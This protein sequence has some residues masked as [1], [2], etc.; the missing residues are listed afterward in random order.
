MRKANC[1]SIGID[2]STFVSKIQDGTIP[3]GL[4]TGNPDLTPELNESY[5]YG[6]V[7]TPRFI[8]GLSIAADYYNLVIEDYIENMSFARSAATC[9][10]SNDFPNAEACSTFERDENHQVVS[11]IERPANVALSTF[12]S[13]TVRAFY[14]LPIKNW[15]LLSFDAFTQ[16][17]ITN[18]FQATPSSEIQEDVGD[19]G[20]PKWNG[21]FDTKWQI[22]DFVFS[23]RLRWQGKGRIDA[24][25]QIL[26]AAH[27]EEVS[28][29][30]YSGNFVNETDAVYLHDLGMKYQ[31][32]DGTSL[33]LNVKNLLDRKP[34][35]NGILSEAAR[36]FGF[37]EKVG[38]RYSLSF[39][40][41]F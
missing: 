14:E 26:F 41:Q 39:K 19:Y 38:R 29:G 40:T 10:D 1:E 21:T 27:Y 35:A 6:L 2:T 18:E 4:R 24:M 23:H 25:Q 12:E 33:Q 11:L 28:P 30:V 37:D 7:Y 22:D 36:H 17:N 5:S 13:V 8:D 3:N 9:F 31:I 32:N 16:H 20:D 34:D 15:G